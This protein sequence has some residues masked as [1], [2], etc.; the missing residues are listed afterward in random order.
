MRLLNEENDRPIDRITCYLTLSEAGELRDALDALLA[1]PQQ[2]H[3][4]VPSDDFK[5]ELTVC[6]YD[7]G[8]LSGFDPRSR[9]LIEADR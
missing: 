6:I 2:N 4:H 1:S 7:P 9:L 8:D 3:Q 5:K